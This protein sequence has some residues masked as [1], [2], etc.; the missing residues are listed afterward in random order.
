MFDLNTILYIVL[1]AG[2][3]IGLVFLFQLI[4]KLRKE[5]KT[6]REY[7]LLVNL[8][9][10]Q[11]DKIIKQS[12]KDPMTD[13][14]TEKIFKYIGRQ[15]DVVTDFINQEENEFMDESQKLQYIQTKIIE[16]V[17]KVIIEVEGSNS[18]LLNEQMIAD[19]IS[20]VLKFLTPFIVK[21]TVKPL[22]QAKK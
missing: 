18:E 22:A 14:N 6:V 10:Q 15:L 16:E 21:Q 3:Q 9:Y 2:M 4:R 19:I 12:D 5:I 8:Q 7:M 13:T 17:K 20:Y 11:Q 1:F